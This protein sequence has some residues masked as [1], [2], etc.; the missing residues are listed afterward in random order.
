MMEMEWK[1][2]ALVWVG[3]GTSGEAPQDVRAQ[4]PPCPPAALS[5]GRQE[6]SALQS[7]ASTLQGPGERVL[8]ER[9]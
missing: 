8:S 3:A 6:A 7:L 4:L 9:V 5:Q 2:T 1:D